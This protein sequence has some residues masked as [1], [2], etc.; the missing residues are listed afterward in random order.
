MISC[1]KEKLNEKPK[2]D[3]GLKVYTSLS[4][5]KDTEARKVAYSSL[6]GQERFLFWQTRFSKSIESG[7]YNNAQI[8]KIKELAAALTLEY[9]TNS[10]KKAIFKAMF[11]PNWVTSCKNIIPNDK[12]Y[13]IFLNINFETPVSS[14]KTEETYG[15][16]GNQKVLLRPPLF[17]NC[18]VGSN[19]TCWMWIPSTYP[20]YPG[21]FGSCTA[22]VEC[23][24]A[25]SGCGAFNDDECDGAKCSF[26]DSGPV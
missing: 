6:T 5:I 4:N 22:P 9:F 1:S 26:R 25:S 18:A 16:K 24:Q 7:W 2:Q 15:S 3:Q 17:C 8:E 19:F 20:G 23:V 12:L 10:D 13:D 14:S 11:L 21:T